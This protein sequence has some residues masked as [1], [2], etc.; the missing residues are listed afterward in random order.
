MAKE[1]GLDAARDLAGDRRPYPDVAG[2]G[3]GSLHA[4]HGLGPRSLPQL[5]RLS[6]VT[7]CRDADRFVLVT[8]RIHRD[9]VPVIARQAGKSKQKFE[10]VAGELM[11]DGVE[12]Q[13]KRRAGSDRRRPG[14]PGALR[15]RSSKDGGRSSE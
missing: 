1:E 4:Q 14:G 9:L 12:A 5:L 2:L 6:K 8:A 11:Q 13:R 3:A 7:E 10:D 15:S